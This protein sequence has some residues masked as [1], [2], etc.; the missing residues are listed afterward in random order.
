MKDDKNNKVKLS[1]RFADILLDIIADIPESLQGSVD[2]KDIHVKKLISQASLKASAVSSTLSIPAGLTGI[3]AS[4]PDLV[5]VWKIQSQL[6]AD[7]AATYGKIGLLTREA[8]I[9]CLFRHSS[10]SLLRDLAVRTGSRIIVQKM[11]SKA[12][13]AIL[14][15]IGLNIST[16]F[17]G[18]TFLKAIPVLGAIGN[19]A[20]TF[21]DTMEVGKTAH[22]YFKSI[23]EQDPKVED[24]EIV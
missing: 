24:A 6:V 3:I 14:Q 20:Y 5:A 11:S 18:K 19:G 10:A 13:N 22:T 15:K 9:W 1:E 21:Y 7:I 2:D 8:M 16:K 17:L 12:L 23:S 4:I